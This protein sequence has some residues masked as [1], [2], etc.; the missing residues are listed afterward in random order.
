M[1]VGCLVVIG[2]GLFICWQG[3]VSIRVTTARL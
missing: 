2:S 1:I 3:R